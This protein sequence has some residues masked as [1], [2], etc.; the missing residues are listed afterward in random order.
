MKLWLQHFATAMGAFG[1]WGLFVLFF[2]DSVGVPI[3]AL[4][5]FGLIGVA[6]GNVHTPA[7]A[8]FAGFMAFLGSVI[9]NGAFVA[10]DTEERCKWC[11]FASACHAGDVSRAAGKSNSL[12][13]K[14]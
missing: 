4:I 6:A 1:P 5:D 12:A 13:S 14:T 11:E 3:P 7:N 8:W 10:A 9:G 2:V